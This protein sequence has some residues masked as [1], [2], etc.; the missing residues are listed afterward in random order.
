[1]YIGQQIHLWEK[2]EWIESPILV[3]NLDLKKM[4]PIN[5]WPFL[6][7]VS[8]RDLYWFFSLS[9]QLGKYARW[10]T[11]PCKML[12]YLPFNKEELEFNNI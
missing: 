12:R 9:D 2:K 1:M 10:P 11:C 8:S 5:Y 6:I 3:Y 4:Q 7:F